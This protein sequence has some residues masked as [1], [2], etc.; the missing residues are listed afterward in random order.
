MQRGLSASSQPSYPQ[1]G[2]R[3]P[4]TRAGPALGPLLP[5]PRTRPY[6]DHCLLPSTASERRPIPS[7]AIRGRG[8]RVPRYTVRTTPPSDDLSTQPGQLQVN[9]QRG[10]SDT[11][12]SAYLYG[13]ARAH[14]IAFER[15]AAAGCRSHQCL[16]QLHGASPGRSRMI[17]RRGEAGLGKTGRQGG[18]VRQVPATR[19]ASCVRPR[20][21]ASLYA[22]WRPR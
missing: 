9:H 16:M 3:L 15:S 11:L 22:P 17:P 19:P 1:H 7:T 8:T 18:P 6:D 12:T 4:L 14:T 5:A 21:P 10:T 2:G 20:S 13:Y